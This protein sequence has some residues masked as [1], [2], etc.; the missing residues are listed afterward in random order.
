MA[1]L[2]D[3]LDNQR[4]NELPLD[5]WYANMRGF[6]GSSAGKEST[7]N[8]GALNLIPG[9]GRAPGEGIAYQHSWTCLVAQTVKNPPAMRETWIWS[10]GWE[11]PLEESMATH[12]NILAWQIP[13]TEEPGGLQ[14]MGSQRAGH[15]WATKHSTAHGAMREPRQYLWA[16]AR[17]LARSLAHPRFS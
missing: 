15:D 1:T 17:R 12:S 2:Q 3:N 7:C 10:L 6:P 13:M 8:A 16:C 14:S 4:S 11:E 9:L 5:L